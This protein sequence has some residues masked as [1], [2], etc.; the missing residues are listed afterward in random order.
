MIISQKTLEKLRDLINE[1]TERRSGPKLVEFFNKYGFSDSYGNGFPSR[2]MYTDE[3]LKVINGT[4]ELDKCIKDLF[5]PI[6]FIGKFTE[7]DNHIA[8]FNQY[9]SFDGWNVVRKET[10]IVLV[11]AS[12]IDIDE[13]KRKEKSRD[14]S[15]ESD[16]LNKEFEEIDISILPIDSSLVPFIES[17]IQ[18]IKTCLEAKAPLSAIFLI[19]STLEG[20]LLG[21][22]S[23]NPAVFNKAKSSPKNKDTNKIRPL[24]EWTLSSLID[25]ACEVGF[26]KEDVK[27]FSVVVRDFRNY[28]H[29]LQQMSMNF[30]PN[31]QTAKICFQ[32]LKAALF[33]INANRL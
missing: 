15:S 31:E 21:L 17:R 29:P 5:A 7:L 22:A 27:K 13:E 20:I 30:H 8:N 12:K 16:F 3:K 24:N 25:V 32:V 11:K 14:I 6:N 9:L 33:Q 23:K 10:E 4:P 2:W 26:I 19:G 1:E 18:E 28:I